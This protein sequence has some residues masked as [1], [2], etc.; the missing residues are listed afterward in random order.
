MKNKADGWHSEWKGT[1]FSDIKG[2]K[3]PDNIRCEQRKIS[4]KERTVGQA[5]EASGIRSRKCKGVEGFSSC[6]VHGRARRP[7]LRVPGAAKAKGGRGS[8]G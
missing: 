4:L 5:M 2:W 1:A 3:G 8:Q 7:E 6:C